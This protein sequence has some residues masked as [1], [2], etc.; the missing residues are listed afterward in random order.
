MTVGGQKD[1]AER[2]GEAGG[3]DGDAKP[4]LRDA[5]PSSSLSDQSK[6]TALDL[7]GTVGETRGADDEDK[8]GAPSA[9]P[10]AFE[11]AVRGPAPQPRLLAFRR[12]LAVLPR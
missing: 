11:L 3:P 10:T 7:G 9:L 5:E 1:M 8:G 12:R 4:L 2:A 6:L